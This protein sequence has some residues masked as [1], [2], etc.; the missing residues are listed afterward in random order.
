VSAPARQAPAAS[1]CERLRVGSHLSTA[2]SLRAAIDEARRAIIDETVLRLSPEAFAQFVA[3]IEAP[4]SPM[5]EKV[6]E[7]LAR[8][9]VW[10]V[11][12]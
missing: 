9:A 3:I 7:R 10:T 5:P 6:K 2:G 8:P 4:V 1:A 12:R 11:E